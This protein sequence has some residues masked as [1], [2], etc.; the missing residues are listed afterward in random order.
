MGKDAADPPAW[1]RHRRELRSAEPPDPQNDDNTVT[2]FSPGL[3]VLSH[4]ALASCSTGEADLGAS[5]REGLPGQGQEGCTVPG[6]MPGP[7]KRGLQQQDGEAQDHSLSVHPRGK[8][9]A[10]AQEAGSPG[11]GRAVPSGPQTSRPT[12]ALHHGRLE[13]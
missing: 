9:M 2:A 8:G 6:W 5:S 12:A 11:T 13:G 1:H 10:A 3:G 4:S 7:R